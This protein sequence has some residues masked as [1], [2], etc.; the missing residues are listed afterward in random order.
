TSAGLMGTK[1]PAAFHPNATLTQ[2]AL[3]NLVFGLQRLLAPPPVEPPTPPPPP[4]PDPTATDPTQTTTTTVSVTTTAPV[5]TT[6][7]VSVTTTPAATVP[8]PSAEPKVHDGGANATMTML[9]AQ[10]VDG[11][12]L[13]EAAVEFVRGAHAAGLDVPARFGTEV[14][15][16]LLGLRVDH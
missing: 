4:Q 13:S 8:T 7:T 6:T 14:A 3:A 5:T 1:T 10:L 16:R 11:V 9:D 2:Q 12:G 15:A